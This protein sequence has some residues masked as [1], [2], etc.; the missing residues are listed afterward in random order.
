VS[1]FFSFQNFFHL[2]VEKN[3]PNQMLLE[4]KTLRVIER[5]NRT[6]NSNEGLKIGLAFR[7]K[8]MQ[9]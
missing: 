6:L 7:D 9:H 3:L 2:I 4:K 1:S 8:A 5:L